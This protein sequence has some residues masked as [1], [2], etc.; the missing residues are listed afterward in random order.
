MTSCQERWFPQT[1]GCGWSI[2]PVGEEAKD[3]RPSMKVRRNSTVTSKYGGNVKYDVGPNMA[4][5]QNVVVKPNMELMRNIEVT[6]TASRVKVE[7]GVEC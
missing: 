4:V 7:Y 6:P 2:E 1:A 3:L 5:R